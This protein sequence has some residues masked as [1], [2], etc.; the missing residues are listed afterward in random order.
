[1]DHNKLWNILNEMG[2]PGYITAFWE[3]CMQDKKQQL[4]LDMEQWTGSKLARQGCILSPC[5]FNLHA[6]Y[7]MWNA[8]L[9]E[10]QARI[11]IAERNINNLRYADD[12]TLVA[13]NRGLKSLLMRGKEDGEKSCLKLNSQK[14]K[15]MVSGPIT[16]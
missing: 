3:T 12:T 8:G 16:L 4:E 10:T 7:I 6:E 9:D 2:I 14:T 15:V 11:Q 13:E 1:M 5:L